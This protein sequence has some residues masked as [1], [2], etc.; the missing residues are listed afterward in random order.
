MDNS[1]PSNLQILYRDEHCIAI[2]K[3]SGIHVH[4]SKLAPH[5]I[6][7][8]PILRDQI[9]AFVYPVHRIDRSSSGIV[10]FALQPDTMPQFFA[11]FQE[12]TIKKIYQ[13]IVR[14]YF[15]ESVHVDYPISAD[16]RPKKEA[17]TNFRLLQK[18]ELNYPSRD[19]DTTRLSLIEAELL[20]GR[21][22]QIRLHCA[23]LRHPIGGDI[24]HGDGKFNTMFRALFS[25]H[26]LLLFSTY[27]GFTHPITGEEISIQNHPTTYS[28]ELVPIFEACNWEVTPSQQSFLS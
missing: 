11:L 3:P 25:V 8:V 28:P 9:G 19:F 15:P 20:T 7:C 21:R 27:L 10:L 12:H 5:E 13:A 6:S 17:Q 1:T 26:R 23:H 24:R 14:G 22:H 4:H 2:H 16:E 18:A